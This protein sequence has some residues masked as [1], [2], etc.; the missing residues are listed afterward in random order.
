M[1]FVLRILVSFFLYE[2][3]T[4]AKALSMSLISC[5]SLRASSSPITTCG[6][7]LR[8]S[9]SGFQI[10]ISVF[11]FSGFEFRGLGFG[12]GVWSFGFG[13]WGLS[14]GFGV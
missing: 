10:S 7:W 9:D 1:S 5:S 14:F 4:L 2:F 3:Q 12:F 6:C 13:V 8:V 11:G